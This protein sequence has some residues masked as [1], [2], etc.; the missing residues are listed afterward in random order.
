VISVDLGSYYVKKAMQASA[1]RA[2]RRVYFRLMPWTREQRTEPDYR[3]VDAA[4]EGLP[5]TPVQELHVDPAAFDSWVKEAGYPGL[6]Y[7]ANRKEKF[8]EHFVSVELL[9]AKSGPG[10]VIDVASC[11]SHFP[12]VLRRRGY[13][14]IAQDLS[15]PQGLHGDRLGGDAAAMD[16]APDSVDGMTLHCSFEHFE[17]DADTR[18]MRE[19]ARVLRPGGKVVILPLYLQERF[20]IET[21]PYI[22]RGR[23]PVDA[24]ANLVASFGYANRFGRHYDVS[25]L[26]RRVL[27]PARSAGLDTMLYRVVNAR[28][29]GPECYLR[30]ALVLRKPDSIPA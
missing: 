20:V 16:L 22:S 28:E 21:D 23:V 6:A 19:T 4:L 3:V 18:F 26:E 27:E 30:Y 15:Y 10:L 5:S 9:G 24:G 12:E 25:A 17:G 8:L 11:R 2:L 1:S 29:I 14:V 13:R 7:L